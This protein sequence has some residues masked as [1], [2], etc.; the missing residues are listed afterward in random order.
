MTKA[1][2]LVCLAVIIAT[3]FSAYPSSGSDNDFPWPMY[4]LQ[5][6]VVL[7]FDWHAQG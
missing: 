1:I 5:D 4:N 2:T 6:E 3:T 7:R